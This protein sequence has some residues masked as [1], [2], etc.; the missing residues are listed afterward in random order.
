[1]NYRVEWSRAATK[2]LLAIERKQ[3]LMILKW[4]KDNLEDCENPKA[5]PG[6]KALHGTMAGGGIALAA[7]AFL[8][9][10]SREGS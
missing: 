5:I 3:R 10:S 4:V 1:M 8:R 6:A 7:T 9:A 2:E